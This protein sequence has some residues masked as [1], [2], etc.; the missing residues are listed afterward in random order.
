MV[1]IPLEFQCDDLCTRLAVDVVANC[2]TYRFDDS[3]EVLG[4]QCPAALDPAAQVAGATPPTAPVVH[5][6]DGALDDGLY[7]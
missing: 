6:S 3:I 1:P 5:G 2:V 4:M 7:H